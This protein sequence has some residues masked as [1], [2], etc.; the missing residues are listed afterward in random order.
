VLY[1]DLGF[2]KTNFARLEVINKYTSEG[3]AIRSKLII[4]KDK[5]F[6]DWLRLDVVYPKREKLTHYNKHNEVMKE[7]IAV[8]SAE[9]T[10]QFANIQDE[11]ALLFDSD[12]EESSSRNSQEEETEAEEK[13]R[14]LKEQQAKAKKKKLQKKVRQLH[15][16]LEADKL[17]HEVEFSLSFSTYNLILLIQ[18]NFQIFHWLPFV[19]SHMNPPLGSLCSECKPF[20]FGIIPVS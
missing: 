7:G 13:A 11:I 12:S 2:A 6:Y 10:K 16:D 3:S 15:C 18:Q 14:E 1:S 19:L 8:N 5:E 20:F 17:F 9:R 4:V